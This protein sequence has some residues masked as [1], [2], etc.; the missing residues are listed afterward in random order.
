[1]CDPHTMAVP[2]PQQVFG[3]IFHSTLKQTVVRAVLIEAS[4]VENDHVFLSFLIERYKNGN[5][6]KFVRV[7]KTRQP[8][9]SF[10]ALL[11]FILK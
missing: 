1:M 10:F 5:S 6:G 4:F 9:I 2:C 11:A 3:I 7:R 8:C